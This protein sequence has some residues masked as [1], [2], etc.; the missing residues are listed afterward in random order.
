[1]SFELKPDKSLRKNIR[2]L[3]RKQIE[4]ALDVLTRARKRPRD[5][6]VHEAR[7]SFKK[8]RA[9]LRLVR[10]EIGERSYREENTE[11]R[12]AA[13][14]LTEVRDARIL[15]DTL[16]NLIKH[17]G[18]HIDG[19]SFADVKK[20]LE[21]NLHA[22]RKRVLF[23]QNAP[24]KVISA[25]RQAR[26]RTKDW[27]DVRD[28]WSAV[29][30]GLTDTYRRSARAFREAN[31]DPTPEKMHEWRK[32]TKYLYYQLQVLRPLWPER[33]EELANETDRMGE[34]LGDD[35]DLVVL[36]HTVAGGPEPFGDEGDVEV[37]LALIDRRRTELEQE[38]M[39]LGQRFFQDRPR[40]LGRLLKGYWKTWRAEPAA[41]ESE[42]SLVPTA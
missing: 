42:R 5:E 3:A 14:P 6:A 15:I 36:R 25:V 34:L 13:R 29:G 24:A 12:D 11:F 8:I 18:E 35:H 19:R 38:A 30:K 28:K 7:K 20:V 2:R 1:M 41:T 16:D 26:K 9:L 23:E 22:V 27:T 40:D 32:Q 39:A 31:T 17:F 33:M 37:L 4:G 21:A 10:P